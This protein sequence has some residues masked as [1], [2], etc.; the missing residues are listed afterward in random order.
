MR[1]DPTP[2]AAPAPLQGL[3]EPGGEHGAVARR[4]GILAAGTLLSRLLGAGRDAVIAARFSA[5]ATDAFF[6]AFTLPNALRALLGEGAMSAAFVPVLTEVQRREG[7]ERAKRFQAALLG[8]MIVILSLVVL[9]GII[10]CP[11]IVRGYA[12]GY[13]VGSDK[14]AL[15]VELGRWVFP[16]I[17]FMGLAALGSAVL[18]SHRRFAATAW[19]PAW[20][21]VAMIAAPWIFAGLAWQLGLAPIG[22][23]ALGA[24]LGGALQLGSLLWALRRHGLWVPPSLAW[25]DPYVGKTLRLL[26][27]LLGGIGVYEINLLLSR[28]YASYLADGAQSYLYYAQRLVEVPQGMVAVAIATAVLPSLSALHQQGELDKARAMALYGLELGSFLAIPAALLLIGMALPV[29]T[30]VLGR[31]AY[32]TEQV[33]QTVA[34]LRWQSVGIVFAVANRC[35]I[36]SFHARNDTRTPVGCSALNLLTFASVAPL[37]MPLMQ[38]AGIAAA[39]SAASFVQL[40]ALAWCFWRRNRPMHLAPLLSAQLRVL[41]AA[42]LSTLIAV[43]ITGLGRWQRGGNDPTN[44]AVLLLAASAGIGVYFAVSLLLDI[45]ALRDLQTTWRRKVGG[46][47]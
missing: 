4:A 46:R 39:S 3:G 32:G 37:L 36:P 41:L 16:Y 34:A 12:A 38:H 33:A 20:L 44:I 8:T 45:P 43:A 22:S 21:N 10:L 35:L 18:H 15:T 26:L 27:P 6:V 42:T 24:L 9:A 14:F 30:V 19:T 17:F 2:D 7:A 1:P 29:I 23:L 25:R 11:S 47:G 28:L 13:G 31:G 40:M 5:P